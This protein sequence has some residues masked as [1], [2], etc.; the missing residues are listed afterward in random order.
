ME[1]ASAQK[2]ARILSFLVTVAFVL[3]L[4]VLPL[5]PGLILY[6][7]DDVDSIGIK[8]VVWPN[9]FWLIAICHW[10]QTAL[11]TLFFLLC[12]VCTAVILWQARRILITIQEGNPFQSANA[13]SMR[14]AAVCC[15][16]ISGLAL[17]RLVL[18]S[19]WTRN[20]APLATYNTLAI[21]VFFMGGLL[22]LVM[23]ALFRQ[24]AD[25]KEDQDLT[26]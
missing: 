10:W 24:A 20:L 1:Q 18:W 9:P 6:A 7:L 19:W 17:A 16:A 26:I 3:N 12:G 21:P 13:V 2:Q 11:L 15:W 14:R 5:V 22:F 8:D 23:S 25:L 4:Y